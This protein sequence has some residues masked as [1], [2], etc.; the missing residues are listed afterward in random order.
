MS[1]YVLVLVAAVIALAI[2]RPTRA[3]APG[4][5]ECWVCTADNEGQCSAG[6]EGQKQVDCDEECG[7]G[8]VPGDCEDVGPGCAGFAYTFQCM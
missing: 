2:P 4:E 5:E 8:L 3:Q 7:G 6:N 1:R